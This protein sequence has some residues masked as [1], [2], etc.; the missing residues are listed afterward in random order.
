MSL[1]LYRKNFRLEDD[2]LIRLRKT[3]WNGP[4]G[5]VKGSHHSCGY[6][7][8]KVE[9]RAHF[10]HRIKFALA[11]GY[12]PQYI[13]HKNRRPFDNRLSNLRAATPRL[14]ALNR[15]LISTNTSGFAGI[16]LQPTGKWRA[17]TRLKN[18]RISLGYFAKKSDAVRVIRE[19]KSKHSM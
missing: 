13:D 2:R 15:G 4:A 5:I 18:K 12:L 11:H 7:V 1:A 14:N 8:V 19:F 6:L 16:Y 17:V 10:I 3:S 9:N